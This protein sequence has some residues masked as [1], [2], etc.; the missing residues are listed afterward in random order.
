MLNMTKGFTS[1][2]FYRQRIYVPLMAR[3]MSL[4]WIGPVNQLKQRE[5]R[6][7]YKQRI[8]SMETNARFLH[9]WNSILI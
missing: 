5:R 3:H 9:V 1:S 6:Q 8:P 7:S 4:Q 2:P